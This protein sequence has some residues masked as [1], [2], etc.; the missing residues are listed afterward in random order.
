MLAQAMLL[1]S[2]LANCAT[3]NGLGNRNSKS[4]PDLNTWL[5]YSFELAQ[6]RFTF[7]IPGDTVKRWSRPSNVNLAN[8]DDE[9]TY[10]SIGSVE[11]FERICGHP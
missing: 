10:D 5:T 8:L 6:A 4:G 11:F 9:T 7:E 3:T 1:A 2:L